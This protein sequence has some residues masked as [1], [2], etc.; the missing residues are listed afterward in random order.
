MAITTTM[1]PSLR[2][3]NQPTAVILLN[4]MFIILGIYLIYKYRKQEG[5]WWGFVAVLLFGMYIIVEP[6][7][8]S[9]TA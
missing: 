6:K 7:S 5:F 9:K 4:A 1:N 8:E 3:K 2:F